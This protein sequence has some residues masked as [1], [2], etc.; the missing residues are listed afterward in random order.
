MTIVP[1]TRTGKITFYQTHVTRWAED[2]ASIGV[3]PEAVETLA[4]LVAEA[5]EA[6]AAHSQAQQA[7]LAATARYHNAVKRMHRGM[8]GGA[9]LLQQ[10]KAFAATTADKGVYERAWISAPASPGRPGSA[11]APGTPHSFEVELFQ[12]G[13]VRLTWKCDNPDGTVG[14]IY[15]IRRRL[16]FQGPFTYLATAGAKKS[17]MDETLPAGTR[18]CQYE[19]TA[20]R[21]TRRGKPG[22][23][24]FMLG[25]APRIQT[26]QPKCP[27]GLAA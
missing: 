11:A 7:A 1:E 23:Y 10:I 14:T 18:V 22:L 17:F 15:E 24:L 13:E 27:Q 3:T 19:V 6:Y 25:G 20:V 12:L 2:P 9:Y 16:D 26:F 4:D 21:S 8:G 5:R